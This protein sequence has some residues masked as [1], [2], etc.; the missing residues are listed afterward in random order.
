MEHKISIFST[1]NLD[2]TEPNSVIFNLYAS[3]KHATNCTCTQP[4]SDHSSVYTEVF[5][6]VAVKADWSKLNFMWH[7]NF[8]R[9]SSVLNCIKT[10]AE[11]LGCYVYHVGCENIYKTK[12]VIGMLRVPCRVWTHLQNK[13]DNSYLSESPSSPISS[14][15]QLAPQSAHRWSRL[16]QIDK[17]QQVESGQCG[18]NG[19]GLANQLVDSVNVSVW[20]RG[21][22]TW[23][24]SITLYA[25]QSKQVY[26]NYKTFCQ[27]NWNL[28]CTFL[29]T[30]VMTVAVMVT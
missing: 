6:N 2:Q 20:L 7:D 24:G 21:Q 14:W 25:R 13:S 4:R 8:S 1:W 29:L 17:Q 30:N 9:R 5:C 28:Y 3:A 11:V 22:T 18:D 10:C 26:K 23:Y 16:S 19:L 12:V 27:H 15:Q